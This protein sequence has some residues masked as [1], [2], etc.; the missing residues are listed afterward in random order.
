MNTRLPPHPA[1]RPQQGIV[2]VVALIMLV[3]ITLLGLTSIRTLTI[4]E[5]M[6]SNS[7]DRNIAFQSAETVLREA[8]AVAATQ[9]LP[10]N[11][12]NNGFP[13]VAMV[14]NAPNNGSCVNGLCSVPDP[15][16]TSRWDDSTFTGWKTATPALASGL[17]GNAPQYIV[18]F[19]GDT[20]PCDPTNAS[21]TANCK[22]YRVTVRSQPGE[23]RASVTLQSI[24]ATD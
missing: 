11:G 21:S 9:A 18:E 3:L 4:E 7:Y 19:L 5:K 17:A 22:R 14:C 10:V 16:C 20:F 2:M 1:S 12:P 15:N 13:G 23:G 24:Y 8:E 6:A